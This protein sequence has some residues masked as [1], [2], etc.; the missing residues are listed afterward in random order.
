VG[1][2]SAVAA[3]ATGRRA[4]GGRPLD[5]A[6]CDCG[7]NRDKD[8]AAE[9]LTALAGLG[10]DLMPTRSLVRALVPLIPMLIAAAKLERPRDRATRIRASTRSPY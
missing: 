9:K 6:R 3:S 7:A 10:A 5:E 4:E 1:R 8:E 2:R